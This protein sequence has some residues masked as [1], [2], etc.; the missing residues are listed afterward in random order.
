MNFIE[1]QL[2][3]TLNKFNLNLSK[4]YYS[5]KVRENY[6]LDDKIVMI[7]KD[8]IKIESDDD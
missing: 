6:Y 1:E 5:G 3:H 7:D 2:N 8:K 4:D